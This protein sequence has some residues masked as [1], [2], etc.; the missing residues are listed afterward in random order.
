LDHHRP[1]QGLE[2]GNPKSG[3]GWK[4]LLN[5]TIF[6][7]LN[8]EGKPVQYIAIR[9]DVSERKRDEVRLAELAQSLAEKNK[10]LETVVCVASHDL[11]SPLVNTLNPKA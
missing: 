9:T 10:E 8:A 11:R 5:T 3:Q 6:P 1:R 2:R 4:S 7:F